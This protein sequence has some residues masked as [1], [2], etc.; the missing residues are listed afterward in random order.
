MSSYFEGLIV[1]SSKPEMLLLLKERTWERAGGGDLSLMTPRPSRLK[2]RPQA[3]SV[4]KNTRRK[5]DRMRRF[6]R[7]ER[8]KR[9]E[10]EEKKF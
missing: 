2:P 9:F 10:P 5:T 1:A 4:P 7:S 8:K 3:T 6:S